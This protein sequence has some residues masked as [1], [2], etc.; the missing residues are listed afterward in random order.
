MLSQVCTRFTTLRTDDALQHF[1]YSLL[2][3][4]VPCT[5]LDIPIALYILLTYVYKSRNN[6]E[7]EAVDKYLDQI[8]ESL[9]DHFERG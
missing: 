2:L 9:T 5:A 6:N 8:A 4:C 1:F 3:C 7:Y